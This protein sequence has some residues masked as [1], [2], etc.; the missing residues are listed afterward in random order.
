MRER[1]KFGGA[2]FQRALHYSSS[3]EP[4]SFSYDTSI[5]Q[6]FQSCNYPCRPSDKKKRWS[7]CVPQSAE[8]G[9]KPLQLLERSHTSCCCSLRPRCFCW[10]SCACKTLPLGAGTGLRGD[11]GKNPAHARL[12]GCSRGAGTRL[13][14]S[15]RG[16]APPAVQRAPRA[17]GR[18]KKK[19]RKRDS[20]ESLSRSSQAARRRAIPSAAASRSSS[21]PPCRP[22]ALQ[23][24]R[25]SGSRGP[26]SCF[27][28]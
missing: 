10:Q 26:R 25:D 28:G 11:S 22:A 2:Y 16:A 18:G 7:N 23:P 12:L 20:L 6:Y 15:A 9:V 17:A 1:E 21:S 4:G 8:V 5:S 14:G 19:G 27:R 13:R 3:Q 24:R